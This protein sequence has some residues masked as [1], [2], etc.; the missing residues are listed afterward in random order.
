M[1]SAAHSRKFAINFSTSLSILEFA[2]N[3]AGNAG[4]DNA[5]LTTNILC[6]TLT[7]LG[8]LSGNQAVTPVNAA[9]ATSP[10]YGVYGAYGAY[11][12]VGMLLRGGGTAG[13]IRYQL[14]REGRESS[15]SI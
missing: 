6:Q 14:A 8:V 15:C 2:I 5:P 9:K 3:V 13:E 12:Q 7:A 4:T 11:G 1:N 10:A